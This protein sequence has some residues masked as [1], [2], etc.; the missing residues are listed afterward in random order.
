MQEVLDKISSIIDT[1]EGGEWKSKDSLREMLRELTSSNYH[2][3]KFNIEAYQEHN[4]VQF[5]HKGSVASG[6]IL[7]DEKVPELRMIRKIMEAV[8]HVIW[9]MRSELSIIKKES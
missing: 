4:T 2:L 3:T 1:Y 6:K 5:K 7:A 8:D 9:S